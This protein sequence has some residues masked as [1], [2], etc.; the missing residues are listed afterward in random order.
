MGSFEEVFLVDEASF[1]EMAMEVAMQ[2]VVA[3][4]VELILPVMSI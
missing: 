1:S 4:E 2:E 3:M